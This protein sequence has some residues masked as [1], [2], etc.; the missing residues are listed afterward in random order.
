[1]AVLGIDRVERSIFPLLSTMGMVS[2]AEFLQRLDA[3]VVLTMLITVFF[4]AS[5][6][7]YGTVIGVTEL[8]KLKNYQRILLLT[9]VILVFFSM[10]IAP[11]T[12]EQ[13]E[14]GYS[15]GHYYL[16]LPFQII[17]PLLMTL[18]VMFRNGF[19]K[20]NKAKDKK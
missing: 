9:G 17:V 7:L 6:Y 10:V 15:V 18:L 14:E 1:M 11:H 13:Y 20:K 16:N 5:I 3:I 4:K 2:I 19:K 12:I 8:F